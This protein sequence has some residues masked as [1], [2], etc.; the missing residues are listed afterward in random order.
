MRLPG[1]FHRPRHSRL[2]FL[3][4]VLLVSTLVPLAHASTYVG[5]N[6]SNCFN[7]CA[8]PDRSIPTLYGNGETIQSP[9]A[10]TIVAIGLT[11]GSQ[12]SMNIIILT[13]ATSSVTGF[14]YSSNPTTAYSITD[15]TFSFTVQDNE[16]VTVVA[17]SFNTIN[18]ANPVTVTNGQFVSLVFTGPTGNCQ[19]NVCSSTLFSG[20]LSTVFGTCYHFGTNSPGI[21]SS[22]NALAVTSSSDA[23]C[24]A[25]GNVIMGA[26]FNPTGSG[27]SGGV[28]VTQCYGNCG[29]PAITLANTNSTHTINFNQSITLFYQFQSN[30]NGFLLNITT[31]MA[32]SYLTIPNGPAFG[33]YT[34]PSCPLG[35][36]PFTAQCPGQLQQ[37]SGAQNFFSPAKGKISF[38]G[39]KVPVANGQWIGIALSASISGLDV[40][41]TNT[42]VNLFQTNEGK[43]PPSIQLP[44][45]LGNSKVGLWAWITG[46]VVTG[47]P[48]TTPGGQFNCAGLL[49]CL[50]PNWV[51]SFCFAATPS[52]LAA[53][54]LIWA[55]I[56]A[57]V[58]T[59]VIAKYGS[60]LMPNVIQPFGEVFLM[61]A[62]VW[63]FVMA[64]LSLIYVWVPLFFF[65]VGSILFGK[66]TG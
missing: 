25:V 17:N 37:Q 28:T 50:L 54:G 65:F 15:N 10:G 41:D 26:S 18:L 38:S 14:L 9:F 61:F 23:N 32:K 44:A 36:S 11:T 64:G 43:I 20:G 42:N 19:N 35:V 60:E 33:V 24:N 53:S 52:C 3:V 51:A 21:A 1:F 63:I 4:L 16:A 12:T 5:Y 55:M 29:T 7:N 62:L 6:A 47:G 46:N 31:S 40:N 58:S 30:V 39:L 59:F 22:Y 49:Y 8:S 66:Q 13:T 56:M 57:G 48:P 34:I 2:L 45:S 27:S